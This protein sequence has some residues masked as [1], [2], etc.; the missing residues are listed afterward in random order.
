[1][2]MTKSWKSILSTVSLLLIMMT[3]V[4]V[5]AEEPLEREN[6]LTDNRTI[7]NDVSVTDES[8]EQMLISPAAN[9]TSLISPAPQ[10]GSEATGSLDIPLIAIIG[11]VV[12]IALG[13]IVVIVRRK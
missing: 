1:M 12:I 7:S 6:Q 10:G 11:A 13:L 2:K 4:S 3:A 9:E 5:S 8:G